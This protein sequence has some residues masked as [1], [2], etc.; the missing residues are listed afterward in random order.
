MT[1][2][3]IKYVEKL[4][5]INKLLRVPRCPEVW[6]KILLL[7][8]EL[9]GLGKQCQFEM[10]CDPDIYEASANE[11]FEQEEPQSGEVHYCKSCGEI[12]SNYCLR[13]QKLWE[14]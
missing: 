6:T 11:H 2:A 1:P 7:E 3:E 9:N 13:C 10:L 4:K 5:E 12:L 14:S 8:T